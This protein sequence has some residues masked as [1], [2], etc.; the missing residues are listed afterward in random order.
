LKGLTVLPGLIDSHMHI[1]LYGEKLMNVDCFGKTKA[2]ILRDV[3]NAYK[4][5]RPGEW[6][7]GAGWNEAE[8]LNKNE[9]KL[10]A[11]EEL[12]EI[13]PDIPVFLTRV[14]THL[15]WANS[16]ALKAAGIDGKTADP[17]GGEIHK[18]ASGDAT[19][20]LVDTAANM[21]QCLAPPMEGSRREKAYM[22][23]QNDLLANGITAANDL[24]LWEPYDMN[25]V[26]FIA[27]LYEKGLMK[28]S[29]N[30]YISAEHAGEIY[31]H[32]PFSGAFGGK[33]SVQGVKIFADGSLG[34][35]SAWLLDD[36]EDRPG[37]RGNCRYSDD[38]LY[39]LMYE[40][41]KNGFQITTHAIGDAANQQVIRIYNRLL[42]NLPEP[43]DH[44]LR[45]EHAQILKRDDMKRL[46]ELDV[47]PSM[48]FS[49]C[50]SDI[51]MTEKR[52]GD[53]RLEGTYAW[54]E[55]LDGGAVIPGGSDA[56]V[57]LINPFHGIYAAISRKK[58]SGQPDGGW[59][60]EQKIT[61][62]EALRAFTIWG[63]Y[64]SFQEHARGSIETGK[65]ANLTI[66]DRDVMI[67]PE[68]D[69]R[70]TAVV[71]T[72]L[73]GETAYGGVV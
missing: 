66:I 42:K 50:T 7:I 19:G 73:S 69:I 21:V 3:K 26:K 49:Q 44:R 46:L 10:P 64:A 4:N 56:P 72:V 25:A 1:L 65:K 36:Y 34:A 61:R 45:I 11:K 40:A 28:I 68:A 62:E 43:A 47:I 38:E 14:C 8:W 71:A 12:D 70:D 53:A 39:A 5:A 41:R 30:S 29:I 16:A 24:A 20:I 63:A 9:K 15:S 60:P 32:G 59:H 33:F 13:S 17:V 18:T 57:E 27:S 31:E 22:L 58:R 48:Q 35:R 54:R 52:I 67:C 51:G 2:E 6:I 23:A 55:L 37:H